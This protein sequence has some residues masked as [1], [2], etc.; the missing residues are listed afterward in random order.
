MFVL[1]L[2]NSV[3]FL[4]AAVVAVAVKNMVDVIKMVVVVVVV[5]AVRDH[6]ILAAAAVVVVIMMVV[7]E[8]EVRRTFFVTP[9][10]FCAHDTKARSLDELPTSPIVTEVMGEPMAIVLKTLDGCPRFI[11]KHDSEP[12][13]S[14][15]KIL[16]FFFDEGRRARVCRDDVAPIWMRSDL[17]G[18]REGGGEA[19]VKPN[20]MAHGR[21]RLHW[22]GERCS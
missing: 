20:G 22:C 2:T 13:S 12:R 1:M 9:T 14:P 8:E 6:I 21:E 17:E 15:I 4:A 3:P 5:M 19:Q 18:G 11:W 7:R 10:I 16:C